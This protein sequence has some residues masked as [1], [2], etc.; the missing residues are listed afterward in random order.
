MSTTATAPPLAAGRAVGRQRSRRRVSVWLIATAAFGSLV[1]AGA[2]A[3]IADSDVWWHV[4][5]GQWILHHGVPHHEPW[6]FTA[7]GRV[8]VPTSWLS[9]LVL[10]LVHGL[11]GWRAVQVY[12]VLVAAAVFLALAS[13]LRK[14]GHPAIGFLTFALSTATLAQFLNARP[15]AVALIFMVWLGYVCQQIMQGRTPRLW[16]LVGVT[17]LWANV[18]G[19]WALAPVALVAASVLAERARALPRRQA[20]GVITAAVIGGLTTMLTPAGWRLIYWP[21]KVHAAAHDVSEWQRLRPLS[22]DGIFMTVLVAFLIATWLLRSR[23]VRWHE[24]AWTLGCAALA[25]SA[26]RNVAPAILLLG[27]VAVRMLSRAW[28]DSLDRIPSWKGPA[29][30]LVIVLLIAPLRLG[31]TLGTSPAVSND[32]PTRLVA[33]LEQLPQ[34][35]VRVMNDYNIGG[36]LTGMGAPKISVAIDGRTDNFDPAFINRYVAATLE[37]KN[38]RHM[39]AELHPDAIVLWHTSKLTLA[40]EKTGDWRVSLVDHGWTLLLP[41]ARS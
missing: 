23:R 21:L 38:W 4:R 39:V 9:D 30:A 31:V 19:S 15:Q 32:E 28:S 37:M 35:R 27:P 17:Y 33:A 5:T 18:H 20:M 34:P 36:Y 29:W 11:G 8:W 24:V 22:P 7:L 2:G 16:L 12:Q 10:A 41:D 40:L 6:A 14:L 13:C 1:L 26:V 3:P 25:L